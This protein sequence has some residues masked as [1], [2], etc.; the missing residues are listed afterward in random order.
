MPLCFVKYN[1][2]LSEYEIH[3]YVYELDI[4]L[5]PKP[6]LYDAEK[7]ILVLEHISG[8]SVSDMFGENP[9]WVEDEVFDR[10]RYMVK[11]L[12]DNGIEYRDITGYNFMLDND[13]NLWIIDFEHALKKDISD[14]FVCKFLDG[15]KS[16]N[17]EFR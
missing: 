16:W 8:M 13:G 11:L 6:I 7:R 14:E 2:D 4:L 9:E 10:A 1:V 15:L 5:T 17:P 3:K 12:A